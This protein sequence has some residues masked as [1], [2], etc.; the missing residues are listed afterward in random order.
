MLLLP[1]IDILDGHAVRLERGDFALKTVYRDDPVNAAES[2]VRSGARALH[3]VDLDGA[4]AGVPR[5]LDQ[6][7]R[8]TAAVDLPVE[9]GGGLRSPDAIAAALEAGVESVILGTAAL[10]DAELVAAAVAGSGDRI[11]V[12]LDARAGLVATGGWSEQTEV[13][14]R[15]AIASLQEAGVRRFVY[16]SIE[17]DG[18]L[19]G[20]DLEGARDVAAAINGS[21]VYSGG[22][23]ELHDLRAL[24]ELRLP[25]LSGVIAGKALYERRFS[26]QDAQQLLDRLG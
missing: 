4:R 24:A 25:N 11:V 10:E 15:E 17:R 7:R 3:V 16:S 26:V 2:F 14:V 23:A 20:P 18:M 19:T 13:P 22:I 12:S 21:F 9:L 1:A 6:V 8:I 5:N